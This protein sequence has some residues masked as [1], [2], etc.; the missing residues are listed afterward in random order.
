MLQVYELF[1]FIWSWKNNRCREWNHQK[2]QA[3]R[4]AGVC[5]EGNICHGVRSSQYAPWCLWRKTR[6]MSRHGSDRGPQISGLPDERVIYKLQRG[7][8]PLWSERRPTRAVSELSISYPQLSVVSEARFSGSF[9]DL[10]ISKLIIQPWVPV[11]FG[12]SKH[13]FIIV[14]P[15]WVSADKLAGKE[16]DLYETAMKKNCKLNLWTFFIDSS[17]VVKEYVICIK[18]LA[19]RGQVLDKKKHTSEDSPFITYKFYPEKGEL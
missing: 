8:R 13:K 14:W 5:C 2:L 12:V 17:A 10:K 7:K 16:K 3:R 11:I 4:Q 1:R 15:N 9:L 19:Q 6:V 18:R